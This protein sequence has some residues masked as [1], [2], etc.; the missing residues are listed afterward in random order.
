M[1]RGLT[2][3]SASS[4]LA[5]LLAGALS[6]S[7]LMSG[8]IL[9]SGSRAV[10]AT[11]EPIQVEVGT[12]IVIPLPGGPIDAIHVASPT[13]FNVVPVTSDRLVVLGLRSGQGNLLVLDSAGKELFN[14]PLLV[15]P[16]RTHTVTVYRGPTE[17]TLSCSPRCVETSAATASGSS[18]PTAPSTATPQSQQT[19]QTTA[20][21]TAS[22]ATAL[23]ESAATAATSALSGAMPALP[24]ALGG[25]GLTPTPGASP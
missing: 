13:I 15:T 21:G 2:Q 5:V 1:Q 16:Q 23:A 4:C 7:V 20:T 8:G 9:M 17:V 14:A 19:Q 22:M 6:S 3:T 18:R 11:I 25:R 24:S 12:S 10:A